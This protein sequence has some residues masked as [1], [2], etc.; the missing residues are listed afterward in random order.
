MSHCE[1]ACCRGNLSLPATA[2]LLQ[3]PLALRRA[4]PLAP[5]KKAPRKEVLSF[6][7]VAKEGLTS[8]YSAA[9]ALFGFQPTGVLPPAF[10]W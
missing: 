8:F 10:R 9:L 6:L 4:L 3:V 1:A 7:M 2:K 5:Q